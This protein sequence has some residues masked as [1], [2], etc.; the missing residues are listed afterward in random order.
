M[1]SLIYIII[2]LVLYNCSFTLAQGNTFYKTYL[3]GFPNSVITDGNGNYIIIGNST[4]PVIGGP[5]GVRLIKSNNLGDTLWTKLFG[6]IDKNTEGQNITE[7]ADGEFIA[8]GTVFTPEPHSSGSSNLFLTKINSEGDT[9]WWRTYNINNSK[10]ERA[11][12][13]IIINNAVYLV[14]RNGNDGILLKTDL[15]ANLEF[16]KTFSLGSSSTAFNSIQ[17]IDDNNLFLFGSEDSFEPVNRIFSKFILLKT[18]LSGDSLESIYYGD[19]SCEVV[20]NN[21]IKTLDDNFVF[22]GYTHNL[23]SQE[24]YTLLLKFNAAGE[25]IWE[26][27]LTSHGGKLA[28]TSDTGMVYYSISTNII[29]LTK[30]SDE[31]NILWVREIP[32]TGSQEIRCSDI[33]E[34]NDEGIIVTGS[35]KYSNE[36]PKIFLL[37]TDSEGLLTSIELENNF[38]GSYV[39]SQN[40]PNPFNPSTKIN[41]SV[42]KTSYVTIKI[43]DILGKEISILVDREKS[44]GNYEVEFYGG[45][46]TSGVYFYRMQAG[47]FI[48]TKKF[49]LLR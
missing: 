47:N 49:V 7:T 6:R 46:L 22:S 21:M 45:N 13:L 10:I 25:L 8:C 12:D 16:S 42:P 27:R 5:T 44:A 19:D 33:T 41:Y 1:Q 32:I 9:L 26:K 20:P 31:G 2:I 35:V 11:N 4:I 38:L 48:D 3:T 39:L 23:S 37:K 36:E 40:Y 24:E 43:Y 14:G 17:K 15:D 29:K 18:N 28:V 30:L 34:T